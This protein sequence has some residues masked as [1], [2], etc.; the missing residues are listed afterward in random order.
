MFYVGLK[1]YIPLLN[2]RYKILTNYVLGPVL[3]LILSYSIYLRIKNQ[4]DLAQSWQLIIASVK[5][6]K[7]IIVLL[8]IL[9]L[10]NWSIE[11]RKWQILIKPVQSLSFF[12][13]LQSVFSGISFSLFIP[14]GDYIGKSLYM[15]EGNRLKS[16]PLSFA[17]SIS[18]LIIT[19]G[20]GLLG[21]L[22]LRSHVLQPKMQLVGLS[23]FWLDALMYVIVSGLIVLI[24]IY[25]KIARITTLL[26]RI[27]LIYRYRIFIQKL[28]E[29]H[30]RQLTKILILSACRFVVFIVQYLLVFHIF[31]VE[32]NWVDA[33]SATCA[34]FLVLALIPT[35]TIAELGV[36]GE[37]SIQLFGLLSANTVGI[38]A[39]AASIWVVNLIIPALAGSIFVIGIKLFRN[40]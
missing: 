10:L 5:A 15:K 39:T 37:A 38:A 17:G 2:R 8:F 12:A 20:A 27:P 18:Q 1:K 29:F 4:Q 33:V 22:Y 9:M 31:N 16:V 23:A 36:R 13:A 32:I 21:L 14:T 7:P 40:N 24:S 34:L 25:Y 26:E 28:E 3:F 19:L 11:A 6:N 30:E 35:I